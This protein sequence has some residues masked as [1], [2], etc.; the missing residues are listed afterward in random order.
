VTPENYQGLEAL[1]AIVGPFDANERES[2]ATLYVALSR[3]VGHL[4]VVG[5]DAG[6]EK[7][8]RLG[9]GAK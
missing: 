7:L 8:A 2:D 5:T 4:V 9:R 3:A 6:L 1:C